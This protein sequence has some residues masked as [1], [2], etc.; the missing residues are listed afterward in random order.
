VPKPRSDPPLQKISVRIYEGDL[1]RLKMLLPHAPP[2]MAI[3]VLL[4]RWLNSR[5][6]KLRK[7]A[8][9][10]TPNVAVDL[11]LEDLDQLSRL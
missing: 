3:R 2:H 9:I 10:D 5:E 1:D 7:D 8:G 11:S 6:A 4:R